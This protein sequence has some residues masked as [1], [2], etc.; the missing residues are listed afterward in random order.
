M[1]FWTIWIHSWKWFIIY[2]W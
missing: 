2:W 1:F